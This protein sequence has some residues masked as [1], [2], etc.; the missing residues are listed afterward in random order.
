MDQLK[1]RTARS[2]AAAKPCLLHGPEAEPTN[3]EPDKC[4]RLDWFSPTELPSPTM[5]YTE[6]IVSLYLDKVPF[7]LHGW[8]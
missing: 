5:A 2:P 6:E 1:R 4:A 7:S 8:P 3:L